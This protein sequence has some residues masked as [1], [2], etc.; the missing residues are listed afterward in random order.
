MSEQE[1]KQQ[2]IYDLLNT[3]TKP[4][5]FFVYHIQSKEKIFTGKELFKEKPKLRIGQKTKKG[6]LTALATAIIKDPIT[7]IRKHPDESKV[8]E[9]TE[10]SN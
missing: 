3:E 6:F 9:K 5:F 10:D 8:H 1:K 4:K 2:R 7:S